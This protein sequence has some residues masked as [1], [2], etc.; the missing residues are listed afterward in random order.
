MGH[1][2]DHFGNAHYGDVFG[3]HNAAQPQTCHACTPQAEKLSLGRKAAYLRH[4]QGTV[5]LATGLAG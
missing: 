3:A 4:Q 1:V 5:M 2:Q